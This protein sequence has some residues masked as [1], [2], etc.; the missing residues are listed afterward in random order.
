MPTYAA[1]GVYVEEVPSSQKVLSAAATAIAAFVGFTAQAPT[2]DITSDPEGVKPRL[3]TSWTQFEKLYGGF[4]PGCLLPLSV[5]GYFQNGGTIAYIVR[6]PNMKAAGQPS[7]LGLP[8]ADRALGKPLEV[9][10]VQPDADLSVVIEPR[11]G[12]GGD[13]A[14]PT[15]FK[16]SVVDGGE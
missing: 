2:D 15:P 10:S 11:E 9:T 7:Q 1:P 6:I 8:A 5:Y 3:V 12:D 16:L 13:S 14:G 4:A